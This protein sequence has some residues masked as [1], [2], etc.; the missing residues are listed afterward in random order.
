MDFENYLDWLKFGIDAGWIARPECSTHES[1]PLRDWEAQEFEDGY[2][3]CILA[4][5]V[6]MDGNEG[7]TLEDFK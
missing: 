3:P 7:L 2:D 4:A 1:L 6:W 5:R